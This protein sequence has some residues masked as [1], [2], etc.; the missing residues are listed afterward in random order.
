MRASTWRSRLCPSSPY[1]PIE[2][3]Y[4]PYDEQIRLDVARTSQDPWFADHRETIVQILNTF[5][6][7]NKGF[8]Y[9]Q[10]VNYLAFP[11]FY[12][13][14]KDNKDTAVEDTFYSLQTL[15]GIVLPVYP[16][17][18]DDTSALRVIESISNIVALRCFETDPELGVLFS[19]THSPFLMSI[20]SSMLPTLYANVFSLHDT[21]LLWDTLFQ[22]KSQRKMFDCAVHV[23]VHSILFHKN[24]FLYLPVHKCMT[25]FQTT[26]RESIAVCT[27]L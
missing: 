26:M 12:V 11:L 19:D 27:C 8:G 21:L 10:G 23:L 16:L 13:Y 4:G 15:V 5:S 14:Y 24:M 1:A 9:P 22:K 6:V 25:V 17:D 20:V 2:F 18:K 3:K 7:V